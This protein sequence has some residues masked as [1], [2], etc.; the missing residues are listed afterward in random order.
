MQPI[1]FIMEFCGIAKVL[2]PDEAPSPAQ[3]KRIHEMLAEVMGPLAA[4]KLIELGEEAEKD[5]MQILENLRAA[6]MPYQPG[7]FMP[8]SQTYTTPDTTWIS[9]CG[10]G[11]SSIIK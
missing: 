2:G 4:R 6:R 11:T 3:W 1:E 7:Y 5:K 9:T 10:S 8:P